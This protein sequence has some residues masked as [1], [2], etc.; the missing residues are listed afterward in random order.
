MLF[1]LAPALVQ[2]A[3]KPVDLHTARL[4]GEKAITQENLRDYLTFIAS[5]ALQG[6]DTPS[7]GL[8]AAAQFLA[9]NLKRFGVKPG[10]DSGTYFQRIPMI[11]DVNISMILKLNT[12]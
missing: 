3:V 12:C 5:D 9:F 8:D 11:K 4:V 7:P 2:P 6:R 1:L 10:G